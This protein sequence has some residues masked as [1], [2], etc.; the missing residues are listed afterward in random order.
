M[1]NVIVF[2]PAPEMLK[3]VERLVERMQSD[4]V[5]IDAV[6]CFGTPEI[7]HHLERYDVIVARGITYGKIQEL[8]PDKH[9]THLSFDGMDIMGALLQCREEFH[10]SRIGL[11]LKREEVQSILGS[12]EE[13]CRAKIRIYEVTDEQSAIQAVDSCQSDGMD[14]VVCGGT[15]GHIC[16]G[17]GMPYT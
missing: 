8:Y 15:V 7:L 13:L 1:V 17:R 3:P 2:V 16:Q 9:V 11:C 14:A 12:L 5:H 6:H 10:P 4:E